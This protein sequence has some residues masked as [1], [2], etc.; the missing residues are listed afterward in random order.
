MGDAH[1]GAN[2]S[3]VVKAFTRRAIVK[4]AP[5]GRFLGILVGVDCDPPNPSSPP[6]CEWAS[7]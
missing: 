5:C 3:A 6:T 2:V 4:T 1:L 7:Q